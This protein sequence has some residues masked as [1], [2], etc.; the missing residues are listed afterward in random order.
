MV[1]LIICTVVWSPLPTVWLNFYLGESDVSVMIDLILNVA[2]LVGILV[3]TAVVCRIQANF[4]R[5]WAALEPTE[6][7]PTAPGWAGERWFWRP[8][9]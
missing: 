9:A 6:R 3:A 5:Y 2:S 4:N 1:I 8:W 7:W